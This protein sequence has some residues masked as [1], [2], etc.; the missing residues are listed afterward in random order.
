MFD[1]TRARSF[2]TSVDP[3]GPKDRARSPA[4]YRVGALA[5]QSE[6]FS[7]HFEHRQHLDLPLNWIPAQADGLGPSWEDGVLP[8]PKYQSF[9]HDL[10]IAS[11]HPGHRGKWT[12]HELCHALVGTAWNAHATPL[13]HATAGRLAELLPVVLYYFLDEV[14][15][16]RCPDH[17]AGGALF[18]QHC[19]ACEEVAQARPWR[20]EDRVFVDEAA[21][22]LDRELAAVARTRR[23]GRPHSHR[24]GSLDLCSDGLA[25]AAAHGARLNSGAFR[26]YAQCFARPQTGIHPDLDALEE[27]LVAVAQAIAL[28]TDLPSWE[29]SRWTWAA[30]DIGWRMIQ[31]AEETD[32]PRRERA[33][34][35]TEQLGRSPT[36]DGIRQALVQWQQAEGLADVEWV[37]AVGYALPAEAPCSGFSADQ[38]R[39]GLTS[40]CPLALE[41]L[42]DSGVLF[43]DAFVLAD[44]HD[45][46]FLGDRFTAWLQHQYPGPIAEL[47]RFEAAL[48][49]ATHD[50]MPGILGSERGRRLADSVRRLDG[51]YDPLDLAHGVDSGELRGISTPA[52]P[53]LIGP[54][55]HVIEPSPTCLLVARDAEGE[56]AVAELDP[57]TAAHLGGTSVRPDETL[58]T[59]LC[60]MGMLVPDSWPMASDDDA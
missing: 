28:G 2:L 9:R 6:L 12:T 3:T 32:A 31:L 50:P 59:V 17:D 27:R 24:W 46:A 14:R 10:M 56:C 4:A 1:R 40:V 15:L 37:G 58:W 22:Y 52:G 18:R 55:Q 54:D 38:V 36:E 39:A 26:H 60:D 34:E 35:I 19:H 16:A 13:F 21:R 11:F 43:L 29:A 20:D 5:D 41:A 44:G 8:E 23:Q 7:F 30:Q 45:R 49:H 51:Q 33:W 47:A 57:Q 53:T 25:Y 42:D 48:R